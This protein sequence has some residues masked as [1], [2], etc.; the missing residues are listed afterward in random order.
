[1]RGFKGIWVPWSVLCL[2]LAFGIFILGCWPMTD[3]AL[4]TDSLP[5]VSAEGAASAPALEMVEAVPMEGSQISAASPMASELLPRLRRPVEISAHRGSS[6]NWPENTIPAFEAAIREKAD[7]IELDVQATSDGVLV[8]FHDSSLYRLTGVGK[9]VGDLTLAELEELDVGRWKGP[10][11]TGT[12][13]PQLWEVF[14]LCKDRVRL[15]VEIKEDAYTL[16][17]PI[18]QQVV[19]LIQAYD[20]SDQ[21]M[22][23]AY[24]RTTLE[25]VK[26]LDPSIRTALLCDSREQL[27][28]DAP[29]VDVLSVWAPLLTSAEVERANFAGKRVIAWPADTEEDWA[30]LKMIG[31]DNVMASDPA[32]A[33]AFLYEEKRP[34]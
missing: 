12:R 21:C 5:E 31:V 6:K 26:K 15:N 25:Q 34:E 29:E 4:Q 16:R 8:V 11:F 30:H 22:I 23:T 2:S 18:T 14:V 13:I 32:G 24:M 1:M 3:T 20:M 17:N 19:E 33:I 10:E 28:Y 9:R 7:W 27:V